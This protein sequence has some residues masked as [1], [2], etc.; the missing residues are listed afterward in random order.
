MTHNVIRIP[1]SVYTYMLS[2]GRPESPELRGL[3][4]ET[5]RLPNAAWAASPDE[6]A[7]L[8]FLTRLIRARRVIEIGTFT[9]YSA[10][11]FALALPEGGE[12]IT[13][14]VASGWSEMGLHYWREAG[15][16]DRID[17]RIGRGLD[18]LDTLIAENQDGSFDLAFLD[19]DKPGYPAYL[20]PLATLLRPGGL[21]I[22]DNVLW[23][24]RVADEAI[25]DPETVGIRHFNAA[26]AADGRFAPT[27]IPVNDGMT[28]AIRNP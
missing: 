3:R 9:G 23:G 22:A 7:F 13:C 5:S 27:T 8:Q 28:L 26:L 16:E 25:H 18:V 14:D 15:V 10:L 24:G 6:I 21:L 2:I 19:A 17:R 20:D 1:E 4:E 12:V 11:A